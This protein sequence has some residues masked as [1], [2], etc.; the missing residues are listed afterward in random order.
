MG[1]AGVVGEL[2]AD[3][4]GLVAQ[5]DDAGEPVAGQ[6][7]EVPRLLASDVDVELLR[8]RTRTVLGCSLDF[9]RM[10][11]LRTPTLSAP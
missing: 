8:R 3:L 6:V 4:A 7:V 9:G 11:A 10:P 1:T 5:G 2:G